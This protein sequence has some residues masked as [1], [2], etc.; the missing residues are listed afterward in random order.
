MTHTDLCQVFLHITLCSY[1]GKAMSW[2]WL[3]YLHTCTT[4]LEFSPFLSPRGCSKPLNKKPFC[5]YAG[6]GTQTHHSSRKSKFESDTS[7]FSNKVTKSNKISVSVVTQ[8][9]KGKQFHRKQRDCSEYA[10]FCVGENNEIDLKKMGFG[11]LVTN[12]FL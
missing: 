10:A 2:Q 12:Y 6:A 1:L 11:D 7:I 8:V 4:F 3:H 9:F 5:H